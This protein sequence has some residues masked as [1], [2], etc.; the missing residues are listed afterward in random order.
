MCIHLLI[1]IS[2]VQK[3]WTASEKSAFCGG[4]KLTG[5]ECI[6]VDGIS[7]YST[8]EIMT[9]SLETGSV[10]LTADNAPIPCSDYKIRYFCTCAGKNTHFVQKKNI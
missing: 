9:C 3:G 6:T 2:Y 4:G 5:I 7:S 10:C 8:G 1:Y